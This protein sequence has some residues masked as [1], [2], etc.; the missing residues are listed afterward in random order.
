MKPESELELESEMDNRL[1]LPELELELPAA[2]ELVPELPELPV[3][4][5]GA[6]EVPL[7]IPI[8]LPPMET[9]KGPTE[10]KTLAER[11]SETTTTSE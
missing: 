1:L 10:E 9:R 11:S 2:L 5:S 6:T 4:L 8:S 7:R 3:S